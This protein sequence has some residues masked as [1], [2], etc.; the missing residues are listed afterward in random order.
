MSRRLSR[1]PELLQLLGSDED[2][3]ARV[4][5]QLR[6]LRTLQ[7]AYAKPIIAAGIFTTSKDLWSGIVHV[8]AKEA[9]R[10]DKR[11]LDAFFERLRSAG[12]DI[13][14]PH[15]LPGHPDL[16]DAASDVLL[17]YAGHWGDVGFLLGLAVGMQLGPYALS[18]G[19]P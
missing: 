13:E 12:V 15:P 11:A 14:V 17:S 5:P 8:L 3:L 19:V 10:D 4:M 18:G 9:A 2:D 7:K 6:R 1:P 16:V